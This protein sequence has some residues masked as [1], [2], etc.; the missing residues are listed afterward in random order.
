MEPR[1]LPRQ[2]SADPHAVRVCLPACLLLLL[3]LPVRAS[4]VFAFV[5][6]YM[7]LSHLY[8]L[9]VDYLGWS[10]DF[11]GPQM[12]LTIKL[13]SF[14]YNVYDGV[15]D[16]DVLQTPQTDRYKSKVFKERLKYAIFQVLRRQAGGGQQASRQAARG[17][18]GA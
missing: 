1:A 18:G 3:L 17:G 2:Q 11:T 6:A 12:I 8:R 10:L 15:V 7:S 9:Y 16:S 4:Q 5:M 13:S 14:A